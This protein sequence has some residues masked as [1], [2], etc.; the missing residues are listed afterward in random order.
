MLYNEN[1]SYYKT[2]FML[3]MFFPTTQDFL[4]NFSLIWTHDALPL[5]R[6][7]SPNFTN[8]GA[9]EFFSICGSMNYSLETPLLTFG[10]R[11]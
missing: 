2:N 5:G 8:H 10:M 9:E 11:T 1:Q 7:T 4:Q 3:S 6:S